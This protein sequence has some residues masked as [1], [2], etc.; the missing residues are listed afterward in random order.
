MAESDVARWSADPIPFAAGIGLRFQH[1]TA[2]LERRPAIAWIEVHT[3]N[4]LSGPAVAVLEEVR[5]D[6]PVS[7]HG[8]GLSLGSAEGVDAVHLER[9]AWLAARIAPGLVSEHLAWTAVDHAHLADLLP[10]PLTEESLRVV[11]HNVARVQDRL[12][13]PILVE[14]PATYLRFAHSTIPEW[15]FLAE[16]VARTGCGLI[17]D[18]N[19]IAVAAANH[20]WDAGAYLRALPRNAVAEFHLAGHLV[21]EV[22]PGRLLRLDTHDRPVAPEVWALF[23]QALTMIGPRP[24][25]IEWDAALPPLDVLLSE[26]GEADLRLACFA[27]ESS[28]AHSA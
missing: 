3:E 2:F 9:V 26:A 17:C 11:C 21:R 6:Y 14:N 7:L 4:Y 23:G 22:A 8:V 28:D 27:T 13:R 25:L 19:N 20:G 15:Q 16:L 18:V 5:R 12:G 10:L 1:H 24:T